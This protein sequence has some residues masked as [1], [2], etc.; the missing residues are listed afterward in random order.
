MAFLTRTPTLDFAA[1]IE[2]FAEINRFGVNANNSEQNPTRIHPSLGKLRET[3][4][5]LLPR[6]NHLRDTIRSPVFT[7]SNDVTHIRYVPVAVA[8]HSNPAKYCL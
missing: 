5:R 1:A 8:T 7:P 6:P 3:S 2:I 4:E